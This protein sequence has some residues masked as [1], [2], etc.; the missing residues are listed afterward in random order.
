MQDHTPQHGRRLYIARMAVLWGIIRFLS[1]IEVRYLLVRKS[2]TI[3]L[4]IWRTLPTNCP[5]CLSIEVKVRQHNSGTERTTLQRT[6]V[7]GLARA[8]KPIQCTA[9]LARKAVSKLN[10]VRYIIQIITPVSARRVLPFKY[11]RYQTLK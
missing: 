5:M 10:N 3:S 7:S 9:F 2:R 4:L 1:S 6:I 11:E 8:T